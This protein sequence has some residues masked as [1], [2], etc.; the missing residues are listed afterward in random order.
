M[1]CGR[2]P[3]V[4]PCMEND[5]PVAVDGGGDDR[6]A[7][8]SCP[9]GYWSRGDYDACEICPANTVITNGKFNRRMIKKWCEEDCGESWKN[10]VM[11]PTDALAMKT[12]YYV[13]FPTLPCIKSRDYNIDGC[14]NIDEQL[15]RTMVV[16]RTQP[17]DF[18]NSGRECRFCQQGK[19]IAKTRRTGGTAFGSVDIRCVD[20][21]LGMESA[22][23]LRKVSTFIPPDV[24]LLSTR[25]IPVLETVP[26]DFVQFGCRACS[27]LEGIPQNGVCTM[28][29]KDTVGSYTAFTEYQHA[30]QVQMPAALGY[31]FKLV[32]GTRC[33]KC[34]AG[35]EYYNWKERNAH[36]P[37]RS[38]NGVEDCCRICDINWFSSAPGNRCER[39]LQDHATPRP[40]GSTSSY[41]C[42]TGHNLLTTGQE[43]VYCNREDCLAEAESAQSNKLGWRAC[44]PC[45]F[46][47][48]KR[49]SDAGCTQCSQENSDLRD[50]YGQCKTCGSCNML[51]AVDGMTTFHQIEASLRAS[52][53]RLPSITNII[54]A[55]YRYMSHNLTATCSPLPRRTIQNSIISDKDMYKIQQR[56]QAYD[57][58]PEF[59]TLIRSATNCTLTPCAAVCEE[60]FQYSPG[61]GAQEI[62]PVKIWVLVDNV[63]QPYTGLTNVQKQTELYTYHGTCQLCAT[64]LK[65]H[66]NDRCNVYNT[67]NINPAGSCLPCLSR[68]PEAGFFMHHSER[69]GGCHAP[70]A[71]H[72]AAEGN[73]K[74]KENYE[75]RRCPTWVKS[76]NNMSIVTACGLGQK[77]LGW[78]WNGD[79][80]KLVVVEKNILQFAGFAGWEQDRRELGNDWQNYRSFTRDLVPYCPL[81]YFYDESIAQCNLNEGTQYKVPGKDFSVLYGTSAY[82]PNCC[83]LCRVCPST[84]KKDMANWQRCTGNTLSDTQTN[85]VSRCGSGYWEN[86]TETE[87]HR[88]S[89]CQEGFIGIG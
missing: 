47:D 28:C 31:N 66:Y 30:E 38:I 69:D 52:I 15:A 82:N 80:S 11:H 33:V 8:R 53:A 81:D 61:C 77:Y 56:S 17:L 70:P 89:T 5:Q 83:R 73:W 51:L 50:P 9:W 39:A 4:A 74:I 42:T 87:C 37:C 32:L 21:P 58:V 16:V 6:P 27:E 63:A 26:G 44:R 60:H 88:C 48:T 68:C 46:S 78:A 29:A 71:A 62:D 25:H 76:G 34:P 2:W 57:E 20:C 55:G 49:S 23:V 24:L 7:C 40:F 85:C 12:L 64:C 79:G 22:S 41:K 1:D 19:Y 75:C 10:L 35:Y 84:Q 45:T 86:I 36:T 13:S 43:L 59:H 18:S 14:T 3:C 54:D 72:M 67:A 65:G